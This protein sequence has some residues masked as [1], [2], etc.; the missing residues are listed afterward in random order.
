MLN[1]RIRSTLISGLVPPGMLRGS[2][3]SILYLSFTCLT[4]VGNY[5]VVPT[6]DFPTFEPNPL[7]PRTTVDMYP[8][9]PLAT[10]FKYEAYANA[11]FEDSN[12][13]STFNDLTAASTGPLVFSHP[14][15]QSGNPFNAALFFQS[16][17][18]FSARSK[19]RF[20]LSDSFTVEI[21]FM[22]P[23][24][25]AVET[26]FALA[27]TVSGQSLSLNLVIN[28]D[29]SVMV[30][31]GFDTLIYSNPTTVVEDKVTHLALSWD[32]SG[33]TATLFVDGN[34]I[35]SALANLSGNF[36][37]QLA[38]STKVFVDEA[39]I[40]PTTFSQSTVNQRINILGTF[41]VSQVIFFLIAW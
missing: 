11:S 37:F 39:Y 13:S 26:L 25:F 16:G 24:I 18:S 23:D 30:N 35:G 7:C 31:K 27:K 4:P 32:A 10:R 28:S 40:Y 22:A 41:L 12:P 1:S 20:S 9:T 8:N 3:L 33:E 29:G 15:S 36:Y 34:E 14:F 5:G 21:L 38:R 6:N 17:S 2:A 19:S